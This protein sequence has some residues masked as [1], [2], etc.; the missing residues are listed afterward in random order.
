MNFSNGPKTILINNEHSTYTLS[1]RCSYLTFRYIYYSY[2]KVSSHFS[3]E[4]SYLQLSSVHIYQ[5]CYTIIGHNIMFRT[6]TLSPNIKYEIPN[7]HIDI[8]EYLHLIR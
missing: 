2:N 4:C 7:V 8:Y 6:T 3:I 5:A 1:I